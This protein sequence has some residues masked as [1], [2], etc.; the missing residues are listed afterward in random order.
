[1]GTVNINLSEA[2]NLNLPLGLQLENEVTEVVFDFSAWQTAYGSGDLGLSIQ[3]PGDSQP[4]A[5]ELTIDGTDATWTVSSLDIAYK[6]VGEIQLTYTVGTVVKKSV[7]YKFTVYKSLGANGE[8]PSPGQTWQEEIEEDIADIKADLEELKGN[9]GLTEEMKQA[10]LQIASKVAYIDEHGQEYYDDLYDS[11]YPNIS[12]ISCLY[13]QSGTVYSTTT[14]DS[15]KDDLTVTAHYSNGTTARLS[16]SDYSLSGTLTTGTSTIIVTYGNLTTSFTVTVTGVT[17]IDAVYTQTGTV[18]DTATLDSLKSDLVVTATLSDS[19]TFVVPASDYVLSGTLTGGT[20]T[21]TVTYGSLTDT[22]TVVVTELIDYTI[23]PLDGITWYDGYTYNN[24]TGVFGAATGEHCTE[25]FDG[26]SCIYIHTNSDTTNNR[27]FALFAWDENDT[28]LGYVQFNASVIS[29]KKGYK[30]AVKVYNTGTFDP[31]TISLLPKDNS[32]TQTA[33]FS[34][35]LSDFIGNISGSSTRWEAN[36]SS[37]MSGAGVNA[38]N[39]N[40]KINKCNY[41][42][43]LTPT[44]TTASFINRDFTFWFYNINTLMFRIEGATTV[45][46][47][48]AWITANNPEIIFNY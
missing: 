28:Y 22:F 21:I 48:E 14:L 42:A 4:Y 19:S 8:Y 16:D 41:L 11:F 20:S 27:Y 36:V 38:N 35:K 43:V 32:S 40:T 31:S 5:G 44:S 12:S 47:A 29:L 33:Q 34:I 10:L 46:E 6:G 18:Y 26:Q 1:M 24:D 30:Y 3:R 45:A 17:S 2:Q 39:L 37:I 15:L 25:K 9:S 23:N 7:I 13:N